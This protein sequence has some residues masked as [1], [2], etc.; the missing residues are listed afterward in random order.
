MELLFIWIKQHKGLNEIGLNF[1]NEYK[2]N[3]DNELKTIEIIKEEIFIPNF[4]SD[5]ISNLTGIIGENGSGKT[6]IL[7]FIL[8]YLS[9]GVHNNTDNDNI[10]IFKKNNEINYHSNSEIIF[11]GNFDFLKIKKINDLNHIKSSYTTIYFS[12]TFDPTSRNSINY[13]DKQF[14]ETKNISTQFLLFTDYQNKTGNDAFFKNISYHD[15]FSSFA[16]QEFIRIARLVRWLNLKELKGQE[17]P[18]NIPKYLNISLNYNDSEYSKTLKELEFE[19]K[20]YFNISK[21]NKNHFILNAFLASIYNWMYEIRFITG[22]IYIPELHEKLPSKIIQYLK[23]HNYNNNPLNSI[24]P[25]LHSIF[26]FLIKDNEL[27]V[28]QQNIEKLQTFFEKLGGF[29]YKSGMKFTYGNENKLISIE[30]SKAYKKASEE[31]IESY[32]ASERISDYVEFYFSHLP[33]YETNLSSGEYAILSIFARLNSLKL[34]YKKPLLLLIDE[35]EL[36]LHPQWQKEFISHFVDFV[37]EKFSNRKVQIILTSHSPFILSDLPTNCIIL[38]KK[39]DG[40]TI[41]EKNLD[42][43]LETFGANIHELFTDTFFLKNGLMGEFARAKISKLIKEIN[44]VDSIDLEYYENHLKN[45]ISIIGEPF[46]R[47]KILELAANKSKIEVIDKILY[48]RSNEIEVLSQIRKQK[49]ND[50]NNKSKS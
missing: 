8:E 36:A 50:Q 26:Y 19:L 39:V 23:T 45:R 1:G 17:F 14:G 20:N 4:Y 29:V 10:Y 40:N 18:V 28:L 43:N 31:L 9:D 27:S 13:T 41:S 11:N 22:P 12:N 21:N 46:L 7:N 25:E 16:S 32:Y 47:T 49:E 35:A 48:Q 38:L 37:S 2:F 6:S 42:N 33:Q 34:N 15:R 24:I 44:D 3:Y 5:N 30:Y